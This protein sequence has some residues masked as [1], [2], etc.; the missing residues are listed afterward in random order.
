VAT[1]EGEEEAFE[2]AAGE[3]FFSLQVVR[4]DQSQV[5]RT[6]DGV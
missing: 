1:A 6:A 5:E 3:V 4:A 2:L